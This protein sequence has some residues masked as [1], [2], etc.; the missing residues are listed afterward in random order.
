MEDNIIGYTYDSN[1]KEIPIKIF[2]S[3]GKITDGFRIN[4]NFEWA[5]SAILN[6]IIYG[7]VNSVVAFGPVNFVRASCQTARPI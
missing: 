2:R 6:N 1:I 7:D 4:E 5:H 3:S